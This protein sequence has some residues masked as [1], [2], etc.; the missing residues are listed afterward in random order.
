M[1]FE[2]MT[3]L[4]S[5]TDSVP[6]V[7]APDVEVIRQLEIRMFATSPYWAVCEHD[8]NEMQ[9]S[10]VM[11]SELRILTFWHLSMSTP[12]AFGTIKSV[13]IRMESIKE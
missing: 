9:S 8:F 5:P 10:A 11:N 3:F 13:S 12:S 2:T 7:I 6:K 1:Q 4:I